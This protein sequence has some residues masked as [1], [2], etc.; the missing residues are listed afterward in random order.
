MSWTKVST[1]DSNVG[2]PGALGNPDKGMYEPHLGLLTDGRLAVFYANEKHVTGNPSYSQI[3]SEKISS[4]YGATW[5][6]EIWVA[7]DST[8]ASLRPGMPVW[9]R[10]SDGRYIVVFEVV[11]L[12]NNEIHYK[13]SNDGYTWSEGNGAPIAGQYSAPFI[14][15]L[16]DNTLAVTSNSGN[17]SFSSDNGTTWYTNGAAPW[18]QNDKA[19]ASLYQTGAT[20]LACVADVDMGGGENSVQV[21]FATLSR[22]ATPLINPYPA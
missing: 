3:I 5:G 21:K 15:R 11:G 9:T 19:W 22:G 12:N 2:S 20:E 17:L 7:W 8:A 6:N 18:N 16:A 14:I 10:M 4:D 13:I 1:I